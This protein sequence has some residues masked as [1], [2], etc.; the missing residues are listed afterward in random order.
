MSVG[1]DLCVFVGV[2][3]GVSLDVVACHR[4]FYCSMNMTI[5]TARPPP[6]PP[7]PIHGSSS[8]H[9][10]KTPAG[11]PP[12][13]P[14]AIAKNDSPQIIKDQPPY[15]RGFNREF[16]KA[17]RS[18]LIFETPGAIPHINI[19]PDT[20]APAG[21]S[22][23]DT[24][25]DGLN[26]KK[27]RRRRSVEGASAGLKGSAEG[28]ISTAAAAA[29]AAAPGLA[30]V[31]MPA[32]VGVQEDAVALPEAKSVPQEGPAA[33]VAAAAAGVIT[34]PVAAAT[35]TATA[36]AVTATLA[37]ATA[38]TTAASAAPVE[39]QGAVALPEHSSAT[40]GRAAD[41]SSAAPAPVAAAAAAL[42]GLS[43]VSNSRTSAKRDTPS[44]P[45]SSDKPD[46]ARLVKGAV[47]G[48]EGSP[49]GGRRDE[50]GEGDALR[51][52]PAGEP[53][54]E[55]GGDSTAREEETR[56]AGDVVGGVSAESAD[57]AETAGLE[58]WACVRHVA[59]FFI[60]Q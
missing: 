28:A 39:G 40:Q 31:A 21:G 22:G 11:I 51:S 10:M 7:Q 8:C 1:D 24:G 58:R 42:L 12:R 23:W 13:Q 57:D 45:S 41:A 59:S 50:A 52:A 26:L 46:I 9:A 29:A 35:A 36:P 56:D 55:A 47:G 18:G 32:A 4:W 60:A 6:P 37:T 48:R 54:R 20:L 5:H 27:R 25:I 53:K 17:Y 49:R 3:V 43:D 44:L 15:N 19:V 2:G 14:T 33:I 16:Q 34:A 38:I 30:T